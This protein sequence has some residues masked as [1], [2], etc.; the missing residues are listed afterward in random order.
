VFFLMVLAGCATTM[1]VSSHVD[2]TVDF[3]QYR[4][5]D[6]G[7]AGALP[8]GDPRLDKDPFF[9]DVLQGAVERELARRG[10]TLADAG[11]A[12][13]LIHYHASVSRRL[14]VNT[15]DTA[16]GYCSGEDCGAMTTEYEA[17]T[18]VV[19]FVDVQSNQVIWRGWFQD[20]LESLI[21]DRDRMTERINEGVTRMLARLPSGMRR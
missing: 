1:T 3:T 16:Y 4:T 19:D 9:Q 12:D 18:I 2:R 21:D 13:L 15:A 20:A 6:W 14:D 8:T 7:P 10:L 11:A 5:Y 17:G